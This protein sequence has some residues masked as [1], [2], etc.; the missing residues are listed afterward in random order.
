MLA[1]FGA[2]VAVNFLVD[3]P[4]GPEAWTGSMPRAAARSWRGQ[5]RRCGVAERMVLKAIDDLGR[6]DLLFNNAG[7]PG[8]PA[9]H[10]AGSI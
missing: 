10:A 8:T 7:T 1:K 9:H 5:R 4:R 3:D 2:T 6:L